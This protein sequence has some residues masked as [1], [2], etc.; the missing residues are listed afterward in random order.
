MEVQDFR[1]TIAGIIVSQTSTRTRTRAQTHYQ[2]IKYLDT[3]CQKTFLL[4]ELLYC[5]LAT[6]GTVCSTCYVQVYEK[7]SSCVLRVT[8]STKHSAT[9]VAVDV[10]F[11]VVASITKGDKHG[12]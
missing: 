5:M 6:R 9:V 3:E 10:R 4:P 11:A 2:V 7:L 1:I 8:V 12:D